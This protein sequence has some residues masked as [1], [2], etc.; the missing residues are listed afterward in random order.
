MKLSRH[1]R[2]PPTQLTIKVEN[3]LPTDEQKKRV[4][5]ELNGRPEKL[6]QLLQSQSTFSYSGDGRTVSAFALK[7]SRHAR[8]TPTQLT[9]KVE[10]IL[11][12]D[13]PRAYLRTDPINSGGSQLSNPFSAGFGGGPAIPSS[14]CPPPDSNPRPP[15]H[16]PGFM[17]LDHPT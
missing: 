13:K 3:I 4:T 16:E 17:P 14:H 9:V 5:R 2:Q 6:Y 10:N 12:T 7:L 1:P 15:G 11:P 8:Q